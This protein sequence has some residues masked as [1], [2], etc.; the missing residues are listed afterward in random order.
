[1]RELPYMIFKKMWILL[2]FR[3]N[4]SK[5]VNTLTFFEAEN[6]S[7]LMMITTMDV[8]SLVS[9]CHHSQKHQT[10]LVPMNEKHAGGR[11]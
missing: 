3:K 2:L 10:T 8:S 11:R 4:I 9:K 7:P 6:S 1:M 5:I